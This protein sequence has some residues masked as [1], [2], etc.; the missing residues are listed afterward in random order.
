M[1]L[2]RSPVRKGS[3]FPEWSFSLR[4]RLEYRG[5]ASQKFKGVYR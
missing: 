3:A 2:C 4:L 1:R 5:I